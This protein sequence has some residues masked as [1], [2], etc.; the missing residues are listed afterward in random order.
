MTS[1]PHVVFLPGAG[2]AGE[3]WR[4]VCERLPGSWGRTL[5]NWPGAG[6][7]PHRPDV[8]GF[9]DLISLVADHVDD[10]TDLVAQSMGGVVAVGVAL[11]VPEKVRRLVL[12]ATS[13]GINMSDH[14]AA[15]WRD[16]YR[17]AYPRAAPWIWQERV[18]YADALPGV[19]TPT[20]LIW[21]DRDPI[22][23]IAV[24]RRL[25]DLLPE[26]TLHVLAGGAHSLAREQ[27]DA[28]AALIVEHL[29][30]GWGDSRET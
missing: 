26:S 15:E 28:V 10:G 12:V 3:F 30:M 21:G 14:G 2:G 6:D 23:P 19:G 17:T 22:S 20:L 29:A 18:D 13:G 24:G 11:R 5:L 4:P 25:N 9:Q 8:R 1:R 7:Q 27:P 16:D